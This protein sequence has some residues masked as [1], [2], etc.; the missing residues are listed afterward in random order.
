M[1]IFG[2]PSKKSEPKLKFKVE[3]QSEQISLVT[4]DRAGSIIENTPLVHQHER[5]IQQMS[6]IYQTKLKK[7]EWKKRIESF[8]PGKS[9]PS[10]E[11]CSSEVPQALYQI[12]H[13]APPQYVPLPNT[14][15]GTFPLIPYVNFQQVNHGLPPCFLTYVFDTVKNSNVLYGFVF[16]TSNNCFMPYEVIG[17]PAFHQ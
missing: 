12:H 11:T 17:F 1:E 4:A 3:T 9:M 15:I 13:E 2:V 14:I 16:N 6:T 5:D 8:K 10:D 7:N